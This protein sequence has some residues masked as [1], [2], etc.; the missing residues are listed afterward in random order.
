MRRLCRK[1]LHTAT[2]L[3]LLLA[4][5]AVTLWVGTFHERKD[6]DWYYR[7]NAMVHERYLTASHGD[8]LLTFR[9]M[10]PGA[11]CTG[12]SMEL[13]V[14]GMGI[15]RFD[16]GA[17]HHW[18]LYVHAIVPCI[19]FGAIFVARLLLA[20]RLPG[21]TGRC[22]SCGYDLRATPDRCPECGRAADAPGGVAR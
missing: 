21:V 1:L 14:A 8:F 3:S 12:C 7:T 2:I 4:A 18:S 5:A 10:T 6:W 20:R 17:G 13:H 16:Y 19:V 11:P 9:D 15:E 22:E